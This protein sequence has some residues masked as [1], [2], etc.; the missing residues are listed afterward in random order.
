MGMSCPLIISAHCPC[1][2]TIHVKQWQ[3]QTSSRILLT[4]SIW[5]IE[6]NW[7]ENTAAPP[8]VARS[9]QLPIEQARTVEQWNSEK[10]LGKV[11]LR[12]THTAKWRRSTRKYLIKGWQCYSINSIKKQRRQVVL[13]TAHRMELFAAD[14]CPIITKLATHCSLSSLRG[15]K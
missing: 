11:Y 4:E 14:V 15:V 5:S 1:T 12:R 7:F 10:T 3:R 2:K 8:L 9:L 13:L 6:Q